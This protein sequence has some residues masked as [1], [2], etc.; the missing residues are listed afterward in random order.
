MDSI[1]LEQLR[2]MKHTIGFE[3]NRVKRNKYKAYRNYFCAGSNEMKEFKDL[4]TKD[5]AVKDIRDG[6]IYYF[7]T[8]KGINY[9]SEVTGIKITKID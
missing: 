3:P 9:I 2:L 1:S 7:L 6:Y 4:I 8:N 5:M